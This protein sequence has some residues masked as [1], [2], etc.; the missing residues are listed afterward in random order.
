MNPHPASLADDRLMRQSLTELTRLTRFPVVFGGFAHNQRIT[1]TQLIGNERDSLRGLLVSEGSGLGGRVLAEARPRLTANYASSRA[2]TH[3]Y[4][5]A[6]LA[7]GITTL[8]AIPVVSSGHVLGV[9]YGGL[10]SHSTIGGVSIEPASMVARE[11]AVKLEE[12]RPHPVERGRT[13]NPPGRL[14]PA[15]APRLPVPPTTFSSAQT[16]EL[17]SI[18]AEMRRISAQLEDSAMRSELESIERRLIGMAQSDEESD[19]VDDRTG[20]TLLTAR[21]SDVLSQVALGHT[22]AA[23]AAALGLTESTVKSY[24]NQAMRKLGASTRFEALAIAR[25]NHAIL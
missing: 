7:E 9:L 11:L 22:N 6:V 2:I 19:V 12:S 16:E 15:N 5:R 1:I 23:V 21:E 18:Y 20:A 8:L 24:L 25:R 4:D 17:R 3:D 10:R 13:P 14:E